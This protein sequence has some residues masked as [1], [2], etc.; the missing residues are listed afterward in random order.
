MFA[1]CHVYVEL[2]NYIGFFSFPVAKRLLTLLGPVLL[3]AVI[4]FLMSGKV[5]EKTGEVELSSPGQECKQYL[6]T[7]IACVQCFHA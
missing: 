1:I 2:A 4:A 5:D 7:F 6:H 3:V